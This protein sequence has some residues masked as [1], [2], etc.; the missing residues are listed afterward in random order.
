MSL[1]LSP[2]NL[3]VYRDLLSLAWKHG[4]YEAVEAL[5]LRRLPGFDKPED[6]EAGPDDLAVDLEKLGPT[7]VKIGQVLS[8]QLNVLPASYM[9][10]LSRLQDRVEPKPFDR[11]RPVLEEGLGRPIEAVFRVIDMDPIG[12]ASLSQVYRGEL[13][14]GTPVAIKVQRPGAEAQIKQDFDALRHVA[15]AID[16]VSGGRY[17]LTAI[18]EHTRRQIELE[19]DFRREAAN[20]DT[21]ARLTEDEPTI[22]VPR[23]Y[24]ELGGRRVLVMQYVEGKRVDAL[25]ESEIEAIDGDALADAT[26]KRY[27]DH[28]L[29]E[30]FFHA[31]P[32]PG[33][34]LL[35]AKGRLVMLDL[36]MIGRL[37]P[38]M[39]ERLTQLVLGIVDGR[40]EDVA[41]SALGIG[42]AME[43][44]DRDAFV[45]AIGDLVLRHHGATTAEARIGEIVLEIAQLCGY[46]RVRVPPILTTIG[47]TLLN[48]DQLGAVLSPA[49]N[50]FSAIRSRTYPI[51]WKD[52][53]NTLSPTEFFGQALGVK[54]L[55]QTSPGRIEQILDNL[56]REDRGLKIDAI[57]EHRL[58]S[59][60]EKIANRIT[61]GLIIAALFI[62]G[63]MLAMV[64]DIGGRL[65]G[66]PVISLIFFAA[67]I[68]GILFVLG[69]MAI[70]TDR[71]K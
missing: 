57:D 45:R 37:S 2:K 53:W 30:G 63:A 38:R 58:I 70:F 23:A 15:R 5:G 36:G 29:V 43:G 4:S 67:G 40:G 16:S 28:I 71:D 59:S 39:R 9:K 60:F 56:A 12:S 69:G 44:Y 25:T 65:G 31:D 14:D 42:E 32:H 34:V 47:K 20:L 64:E 13:L 26:F 1:A 68:A 22:V 50:P 41:E 48:L 19:L 8:A 66:V 51:A 52:F 33:N 17:N 55:A 35:D 46:H 27:L 61:Y 62:A 21:L 24:R 54:R 18:C 11:L 49:Y 6:V 7:Y 3:S 10:A